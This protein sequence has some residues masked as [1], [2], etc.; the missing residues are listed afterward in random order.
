MMANKY[1]FLWNSQ[2]NLINFKVK[3]EV[4]MTPIPMTILFATQFG[5]P[6]AENVF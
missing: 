3:E 1:T 6:W 2:P 5:D 4:M